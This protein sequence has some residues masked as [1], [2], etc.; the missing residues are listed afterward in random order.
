MERNV[1]FSLLGLIL[2]LAAGIA[3]VS[4]YYQCTY[5]DLHAKYELS[6][7]TLYKTM[8]DYQEKE[9]I[10][11]DV[12]QNLSISEEREGV[13]GEKYEEVET[14]KEGLQTDLAQAN[15]A[16]VSLHKKHDKLQR[17]YDSL[18]KKYGA[19]QM[20]KRVLEDEV[21]D[22]EN[23]VDDLKDD[24]KRLN[25]RIDELEAQLSE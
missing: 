24:V 10:L 17:D 20:E 8:S 22:L 7:E 15:E 13:L 21:D 11:D 9:R 23:K 5:S 4:V 18:N 6:N 16:L 19:L 25:K 2:L 14:E 3:A 1:S 12:L